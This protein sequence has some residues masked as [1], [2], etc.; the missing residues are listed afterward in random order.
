M[1]EE[2]NYSYEKAVALLIPKYKIMLINYGKRQDEFE[3]FCEDFVEDIGQLSKKYD[4]VKLLGRPRQW[5]EEFIEKYDYDEIVGRPLSEF[6]A[7]N[8]LDSNEK[9]RKGEFL[10]S[11]LT[12]SI[13]DIRSNRN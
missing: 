8:K 3:D 1:E 6:L 13:N 10:I 4:Y 5:K 11:L 9:Q 7:W 12:G 2:N